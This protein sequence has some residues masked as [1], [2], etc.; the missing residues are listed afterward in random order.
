MADDLIFL[1]ELLGLKVHDL[2]GRQLGFVKDAAIVPL[3]HPARV[4]R[5]LVGGGW[6][7]L[8]VKH[9][10]VRS[11]SLDGI[12][13]KDEQLTPYHSDEYMLR[14]VRDLLDQ[15][16]I[17]GQGRK[18][19]RVTDVTFR[20]HHEPDGD[21]MNIVEV[22][23]GLRSMFRRL[24]QGVI[25]RRLIR[26]VQV[27]IPPHSIRWEHCTIIEADPQVRLR[28]NIS[29]KILER[30]HPADLADIVEDL[31]P[32]DREAIFEPMDSEGPADPLRER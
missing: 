15:Q 25:P 1:T 27:V 9:D 22:D 6:A 28:L 31:T 4:D 5:F 21:V 13:L 19:V 29:N 32:E 26:R 11:I 8:T 12:F 30:M 24:G 18:V 7:W 2:K 10:Q 23:I 20:I 3:I 17:D 14:L 16:I